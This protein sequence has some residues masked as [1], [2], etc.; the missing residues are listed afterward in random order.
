MV[1]AKNN[2]KGIPRILVFRPTYEEFKDFTKYVE[3][4]ESQ[5]AHKAG[6]AKVIPP[7]EWVPRKE[8]YNLDDLNLIIPAP[9]CQVVNGKQGLYQQINIQKKPMTVKEY[10][11]LATSDRYSTPRHF[12]YEDL[13]RKYWKNITYIAPIYGADVSGSLTDPDVKEWN[14]NHLGTILDYVNKDYGISIDGVNTAYL[15]FGMWKT[16]FAWHTED[17]DLYSINYLHFG[18]PKTWYAI[19]PEHGRRLER[20]ASGFFQASHQNCQAFLRHKMTLISP[21]ILKQYS[22][23]YNRITQEAGEIMITFPYGYHAGFNHGFNCAESTNFA[24]PR[25]VEYG[26]RA[27]QCTCSKDMVKISMDTFVKRFQPERYDLWLRGEDIGPH[28][29]DPRQTAAPMPSQMDLLCSNNSDGQLPQSYLNAVPKNKRHMI[30]GKKKIIANPGVDVEDIM[31]NADIPA[32]VKKAIQDLEYEELDDAPD[33]QQLEVLEDIWLKAGEMEVDEATVYDDGYNRK[34]SRKRKKKQNVNKERKPKSAS[35]SKKE[36]N[37]IHIQNMDQVQMKT[38]LD[39]IV[40]EDTSQENN[41]EFLVPQGNYNDSIIIEN[42]PVDDPLKLEDD[43]SEYEKPTKRRRTQKSKSSEQKKSKSR[44][45]VPKSRRKDVNKSFTSHTSTLNDKIRCKNIILPDLRVHIEDIANNQGKISA[46]SGNVLLNNEL[47]TTI[48]KNITTITTTNDGESP[49][50]T[51]VHKEP[52]TLINSPT[53]SKATIC[54]LSNIQSDSS[55]TTYAN[56]DFTKNVY[57]TVQSTNSGC[58]NE[59]AKV[60]PIIRLKQSTCTNHKN[61]DATSTEDKSV[62]TNSTRNLIKAPRLTV[63]PDLFSIKL[64]PK[65]QPE[66]TAG[67]QDSTATNTSKPWSVQEPKPIPATNMLFLSKPTF[68][69]HNLPVL[70][71]EAQFVANNNTAKSLMQARLEK[72]QLTRLPADTAITQVTQ[73]PNLRTIFPRNLCQPFNPRNTNTE[74]KLVDKE[75]S[76]SNGSKEEAKKFWE[77]SANHSSTSKAQISA[78]N[79]SGYVQ[80]PSFPNLLTSLEP[81]T[82]Q[83]KYDATKPNTMFVSRSPTIYPSA[84]IIPVGIKRTYSQNTAGSVPTIDQSCIPALIPSK[85]PNTRPNTAILKITPST[86][87]QKS[88]KEYTRKKSSAKDAKNKSSSNANPPQAITA[89]ISIGTQVDN[90]INVVTSLPNT[91]NFPSRGAV[92]SNS[93]PSIE[94]NPAAIDDL[95]QHTGSECSSISDN[96]TPSQN[97]LQQFNYPNLSI[98]IKQNRTSSYKRKSKEKSKKATTRRKEPATVILAAGIAQDQSSSTETNSTMDVQPN[99]SQSTSVIPGHISDMIH[100]NVPNSDLLKAFNNYWSAQI[101][102]CAVCATFALCSSGSS[103]MMPPDWKYCESTDLPENSPIWVSSSIFAA[104]SKEQA[105][106]PENKKLLRCR[107]CHVTVHASCYGITILP[108]DVRNW[109]CDRCKAGRNDVMCC[110]CPMF[111]GPLKRTSDSRWAHILCTL[112]VPGATFKD[113]INKDPINVLTINTDTCHKRCCFCGLDGGAC[114]TCNQCTKAFHPSCGLVAGATF[115]IPVYNSQEIQVTCNGHDKGKE[116]V[117]RQIRQGE[118]VWAKHRN[119]RYYQA[120]VQSIQDILFYMVTFNDNSF[121]DDLYPSDITNYDPGNIPALGAAVT[122]NWTDGQTYNGVFEGTNHRI[123][124]TVTFEDGSQLV[125]KRNE[126]YS[127]QE[128][129][130]KR[131]RSRLSVATEMKHRSHLYGSADETKAQRKLTDVFNDEDY[132]YTSVSC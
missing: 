61:V 33:E 76:T 129:M 132:N 30:H 21:Q 31:N 19:P 35:K 41:D 66:N 57:A 9:I 110:L 77:N 125:L 91:N 3:Y 113:A 124:F 22:I 53:E 107:E 118:I 63:L 27:M 43:I 100:P 78:V 5:G 47:N 1:Y 37:K 7:S 60:T 81:N 23:P 26:K 131:V 65:L 104:N 98:S 109:A 75:M 56:T 105:V 106:E 87:H 69:N 40:F 74:I 85:R 4:M 36:T 70:Q 108:T 120:K 14:I 101:S 10:S 128:D 39:D 29:E 127:L 18:A 34:K 38:E 16:T 67:N 116:K 6:L 15:Y 117:V 102:H 42:D 71:N 68:N 49:N 73:V 17:M 24:A 94:K 72:F 126:I 13:E 8:G 119:T 55:K 114:L 48:D 82:F 20:L 83:T 45:Y 28:P 32:D 89:N 90:P 130:P 46:L 103:K 25:W 95:A 62:S 99:S 121:S 93:H 2:K 44:P 96:K 12:D 50:L 111:G 52:E 54:S 64:L 123:M 80:I 92:Y 84:Q 112:M 79:K 97:L 88:R 58:Q 11:R 86:S 115:I 122:V 51:Y 59:S